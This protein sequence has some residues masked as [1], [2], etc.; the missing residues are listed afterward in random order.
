VDYHAVINFAERSITL[1]VIGDCTKVGFT[2]IKETTDELGD[3]EESSSENEF[4]SFALVSNFPRKLLSLTADPGQHP[5]DPTV[6][7]SEH[8]L[9]KNEKGGTS[10]SEKNKEQLIED[11]VDYTREQD[12]GA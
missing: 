6:T 7:V 12:F 10:V 2:G 3:N 5:T 11:E 4:H 8:T 9:V 1:K